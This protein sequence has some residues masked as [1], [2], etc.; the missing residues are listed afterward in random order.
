MNEW[1]DSAEYLCKNTTK[2]FLFKW[3]CDSVVVVVRKKIY[4]Q[5]SFRFPEHRNWILTRRGERYRFD[6]HI[7]VWLLK[8]CHHRSHPYCGLIVFGYLP[9]TMAIQWFGDK[10]WRTRISFT[11]KS[12]IAVVDM[13]N[14]SKSMSNPNPR[15]KI[16][17]RLLLLSSVELLQ[18]RK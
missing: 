5:K 8:A 2:M 9:G 1:C 17:V 18:S 12:A 16:K 4:I 11:D 14:I 10:R 13:N 3:A 6:M 7:F 15:T